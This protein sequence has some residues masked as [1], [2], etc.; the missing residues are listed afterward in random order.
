MIENL[1]EISGHES[2]G[3]SQIIYDGLNSLSPPHFF[4]HRACSF[5]NERSI[6]ERLLI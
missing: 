6:D 1:L 5:L 3:Y 2:H 4:S